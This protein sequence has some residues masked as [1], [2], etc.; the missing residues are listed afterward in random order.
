MKQLPKLPECSRREFLS[1]MTAGSI[2]VLLAAGSPL[3]KLFAMPASDQEIEYKYQ[4]R[5]V[6]VEHVKQ[7]K[8]W[9]DSLRRDKKLG[10]NPNFQ[11][12]IGFEFD[13]TKI[14]K[15]ARSLIVMSRKYGLASVTFKYKGKDIVILIPSGYW[16]DYFSFDKA[17]ALLRKDVFKGRE[18]ALEWSKLPLKTMAVRSGLAEYGLNNISFVKDFGSFHELLGFY[19]D[20]EM[21]DQWGPLKTMPFCKGCSI[22]KKACPTKCIR[23]E[24]F[25]IDIDH[26]LTLYNELPNAFPEWLPENV[27]H[28]MVGCLKCQW[29]CPA[30]SGHTSQITN[31]ATLTEEETSLILNQTKD[32]KLQKQIQEKLKL[33]YPYV[34]NFDY[35][36]RNTRLALKNLIKP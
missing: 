2:T 1:K 15:N 26:C 34:G 9:F 7:V 5:S 20:Q 8:E 32:E 30:N 11:S 3:G 10:S 22:C 36:S 17:K 18:V 31:L 16:D 19:T 25:V 23:D 28:T 13:H 29:D 21:E 24:E 6:S 33:Q 12:Y 35:F 27:H 14:L 4:F